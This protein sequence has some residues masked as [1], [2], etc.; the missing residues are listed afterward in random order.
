MRGQLK[1]MENYKFFLSCRIADLAL[2]DF[3]LEPTEEKKG[4]E[5]G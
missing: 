3:D 5:N 4:G 2:S 1:A